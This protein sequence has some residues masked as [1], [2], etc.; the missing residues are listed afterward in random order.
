MRELAVSSGV[1]EEVCGSG[2][3][4]A[5]RGEDV[6]KRCAPLVC[7]AAA[8]RGASGEAQH[9]WEATRD[10]GEAANSSGGGRS[11]HVRARPGVC[12]DDRAAKWRA[13]SVDSGRAA[14]GS[15][16][17]MR[18]AASTSRAAGY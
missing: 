2:L 5:A 17:C 9:S 11:P 6:G 12:G 8:G 18:R 4:R 10:G 7:R 15:G 13:A 16:G 14:R 1:S 3:R